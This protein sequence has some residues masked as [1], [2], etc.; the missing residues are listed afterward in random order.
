MKTFPITNARQDIFNIIE[1]TIANSEP[2]QLTS[3]KGDVVMVSLADWSAMQ[4]TL[5]LLGISGM[6]ESILDGAKE[7]T[8]EC[9]S[10]EDI[11]WDI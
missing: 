4:E 2:I 8:S 3:K 7:T 9:K 11:G 5:Y 10:L 6:R 1:Q